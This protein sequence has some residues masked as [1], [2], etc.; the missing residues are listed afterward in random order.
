[1]IQTSQLSHL[2]KRFNLRH[3][4]S[5]LFYWKDSHS[6]FLALAYH[7]SAN[8]EKLLNQARI[9]REQYAMLIA[10]RRQVTLH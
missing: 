2:A 8:K 9:C 3:C 5:A 6:A 10:L 4:S 1:M 7:D